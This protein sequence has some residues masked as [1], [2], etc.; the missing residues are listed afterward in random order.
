VFHASFART[1]AEVLPDLPDVRLLLQVDDSSGEPLLPGALRYEDALAAAEP[2]VPTGLSPDDLYILYTGGTT[3]LPKGVLWRQADFL[4]SCLGIASTTEQLVEAA[5]PRSLRLLAAPPFMHG[6]AHWNAISGWT[7]GGTVVIQ[8]VPSRLDA[9]DI[10]RT[11]A[12]EQATSLLIVGDAFAR[13]L[14]DALRKGRHDVGRLQHL[15]TGGAVLSA[16]VK[17]ELLAL[18]PG[19]RI[20]DVLGSSETGRQGVHTSDARHGAST[21]TFAPS[22]TAA[23]L[24]EDRTRVLAAGDEELGWLAQTGRVPRGYLGDEEKTRRTFPIVDGVRYA[25]AGDRARLTAD[26]AVELHGRDSVTIN[27]GGEKVFAEEV[28]QALKHHPAVFDAVVVG[29]ASERWGQEVV[30]VVSLR[31]DQ[32]D[33]SDDDLREVAAAHVARYKLPKDVVRVPIVERSPSGKPDYRWAAAVAAG[34]GDPQ[35]TP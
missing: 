21:G 28:E 7:S 9:D 10:L 3:G 14:V 33:P 32:P 29:R 1:L 8:D 26:G 13:P 16:P 15:L 18:V 27:T 23:V 11:L 6:A 30:A 25:V 35:G 17:E 31:E 34:L 22:P 20:V 5:L 2:L 12:R 24:C 4:A 19:L